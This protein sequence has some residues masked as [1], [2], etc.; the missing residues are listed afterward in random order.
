MLKWASTPKMDLN[1]YICPRIWCRRDKIALTDEQLINN[2]GVCPF[3]NGEI[4]DTSKK[5][6]GYNETVIIRKSGSNKYW[7]DN[8]IK[9]KK[10]KNTRG[11]EMAK[12]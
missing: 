8:E 4:V 5:E 7:A 10:R 12:T 11:E 3:C 2:D 9:K 6:I 1:Y